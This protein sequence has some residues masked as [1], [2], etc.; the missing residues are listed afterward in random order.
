MKKENIT[1]QI[2]YF[3]DIVEQEAKEKKKT[4]QTIFKLEASELAGQMAL[5]YEKVRTAVQYKEE[6]L[7]RRAAIYRI[8]KR[9]ITIEQRRKKRQITY[10]F[11]LELAMAGYI[12]QKDANDDNFKKTEK[13]IA[14]Y[15]KALPLIAEIT[16]NPTDSLEV[17]GWL[18]NLASEEIE[19]LINPQK[20][21][22]AYIYAIY[23]TLRPKIKFSLEKIPYPLKGS[24]VGGFQNVAEEYLGVGSLI[25]PVGNMFSPTFRT[26]K[27][28]ENK[29]KLERLLNMLTYISIFRNLRRSDRAMIRALV[30]NIYFPKWTNLN[31][32]DDRE[33]EKTIRKLIKK[34]E[35]MEIVAEHPLLGR[36]LFPIKNYMLS[37]SFFFET[38]MSNSREARAIVSQEFLLHQQIRQQCNMRYAEEK[39]KLRKRIMRGILYV[40]LT[41]MLV[42][43]ILE[44]PYEMFKGTGVIQYHSLFINLLFP[45]LL[46]GAIASSVKYPKEDNTKEIIKNAEILIYQQKQTEELKNVRVSD[47]ESAFAERILDLFYII[48]FFGALFTLI[49]FLG[50]IGFNVVAMII[51]VIFTGTVSF[52]GALIRQSIRDLVATKD[53]EGFFSLL[54]DTILLPFVRLGRLLSV[55]FSQINVLIFI[56]DF[57]I[58]APFKFIIRAFEAWFDFLRRKRDEIERQFD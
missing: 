7:L 32:D 58:E 41:K 57:L 23:E 4:E 44:V 45:P 55:K 8:L 9:L 25:E 47:Q 10:A 21:R 50:F 17:K 28:A 35:E 38:I 11:F 19:N 51:F 36:I 49:R 53:K 16:R 20:E 31:A 37:A 18:L 26:Q 42:A 5:W 1:P 24:K 52:F 15:L 33:I 14:R 48:L 39:K 40:F 12:G 56:L 22:M 43:L 46:L 54:F 29:V 3:L 27:T 6:H 30:F 2:D 34:K 13:I